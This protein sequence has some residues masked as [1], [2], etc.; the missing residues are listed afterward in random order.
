MHWS[1]GKAFGLS[2]KDYRKSLTALRKA[3]KVTET[4]L[5]MGT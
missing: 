3:L 5:R 1:F 4:C 2:E